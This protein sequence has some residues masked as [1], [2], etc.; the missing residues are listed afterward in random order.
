M[1]KKT[2]LWAVA[3][4]V[5]KIVDPVDLGSEVM[6]YSIP[7]LDESG[8][9][10]RD[11]SVSIRSAKLL[12]S[13]DE[14]LISKLNPRKS[15]VVLVDKFNLPTVSSTELVGLRPYGIDRR[16]LYYFLQGEA[17]RQQLDSMVQSVTRSHQ[18]V[19]PDDILRLAISL[20]DIEMQQRI[21]DFLDV[22]T[23]RIDSLTDLVKSAVGLLD[24]R[25]RLRVLDLVGM[26]VAGGGLTTVPLKYLSLAISVGIVIT[27][28]R[29]YVDGDGVVALRGLNVR[30]GA[31]NT[32]D[33]VQISQEGHA[34]HAK[35]RLRSGDVVVVRT[36]QTGVAAVVPESLDGCN[37]I[38][39]VIVRPK[40]GI[41]L[42]TWRLC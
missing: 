5:R 31:I 22:E 18:R 3:A 23:T 10:L 30:P 37:C 42:V 29:W 32:E 19:G 6:H 21:A 34:L 1:S 13:G 39:L 20:P 33:L 12:L 26:S 35:S 25:L 28:A 40:P 14:V 2:P 16:F 17:T 4:E 41:K 11:E 24:T 15:R 38:D 36:G 27:P 9:A 7:A 8:T